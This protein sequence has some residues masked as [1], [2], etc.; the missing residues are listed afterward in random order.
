M[1]YPAY[2]LPNMRNQK[3]HFEVSME[4]LEKSVSNLRQHMGHIHQE[5]LFQGATLIGINIHLDDIEMWK[6]A[7]NAQLGQIAGQVQQP[8]GTL[9]DR[10]EENPRIVVVTYVSGSSTA[11]KKKNGAKAIETSN[12]TFPEAFLATYG[13][14]NPDRIP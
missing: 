2:R 1:P 13:P 5:L 3:S 6:K 9:P 7:T 8:R 12:M 10:P 4:I 11:K 14:P